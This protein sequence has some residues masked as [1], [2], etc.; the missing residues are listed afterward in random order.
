MLTEQC[1]NLPTLLDVAVD[2]AAHYC[3]NITV[4]YLLIHYNTTVIYIAFS[5][6]S[7]EREYFTVHFSIS[8]TFL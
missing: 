2:L 8:V 1:A 7:I 3:K 6:I 5:V 4:Q